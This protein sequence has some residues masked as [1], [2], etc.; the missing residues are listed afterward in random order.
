VSVG[1]VEVAVHG[2]DVAQSCGHPRPIPSPLSKALLTVAPTLV[3]QF[4]RPV[5]FAAA[6]YA[7]PDANPSDRLLAYL[8]RRP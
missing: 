6:R 5:R 8:G 2:W 3:T 4:D 1:A 7:S